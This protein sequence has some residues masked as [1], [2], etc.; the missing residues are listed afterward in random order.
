MEKVVVGISGRGRTLQNLLQKEKDYAYRICGVFSSRP[1]AKGLEYAHTAGLPTLVC[2]F[3]QGNPPELV[4][5]IKARQAKGIALAGFTRKFPILPGFEETAISI[6]PSLLPAFGGK[7]MFGRH[8]HEAVFAAGEKISGATVHI[9]DEIYDEGRFIAQ[10]KVDISDCPS[11]S[12]VQDRVFAA[13]CWVYP[14]VIDSL[15]RN[16]WQVMPMWEYEDRVYAKCS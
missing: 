1:D 8:V 13:E 16:S 11:A 7:G 9:V 6:H 15:V 3:T 12:A 4:A 14:R 5:W 10:I 2:D